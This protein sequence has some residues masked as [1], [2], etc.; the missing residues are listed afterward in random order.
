MS[1]HFL[2]RFRIY[3]VMAVLG[4]AFTSSLPA[5]EKWLYGH[6]AHFEMLSSA[7]EKDSRRL[8]INL[9][10]FRENVLAMFPARQMEEPKV[11]VVLFGSDS[12]FKAYKPRY[13]GKPKDVAGYFLNHP[14]QVY[15]A[16]CTDYDADEN[17]DPEEIIFH[18]YLH[19]LVHSRGLTLP[20]WLNEGMAEVFSTF[21]LEDKYA[22]YGAP[23][24]IYVDIMGL[25][26]LMPLERMLMVDE[27]SP[28]YNEE[29]RA[30]TFYAQSWL[31]T[32][33]LLCG[34]DREN[35][36]RLAKF[37]ERTDGMTGNPK[38]AFR[39]IFGQSVGEME[40]VLRSYLSG[41]QFYQRRMPL[42]PI[43]EKAI[44]VRP[45]SELEREL[46]LTSLRWR[47]HQDPR[48]VPALF[49]L[50]DRDPK[51]PGPHETLAAVALVKNDVEGALSHWRKAAELK[52]DNPFVYTQAARAALERFG[53]DDFDERLTPEEA[54]ELQ[55]WLDR[56]LTLRPGYADAVEALAVVESRAPT[57]RIYGVNLIQNSMGTMKDRDRTL[58]CLA[59]IRWRAKDFA[60][61]LSIV[62][63]LIKSGQTD[64]KV[65]S[66]AISLK[67]R[68]IAD[69]PAP[70][71]PEARAADG[72]P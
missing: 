2:H 71:A 53:M 15:I 10:R 4:L 59:L 1:F 36:K 61:C 49:A 47:V 11:T 50:A 56:A 35:S 45:A 13:K 23:K 19:L 66:A 72:T 62:E 30:T 34:K 18:E 6:S 46:V 65:R 40:L 16:M 64:P 3:S 57:I 33:Y 52:T 42:L 32:H 25:S 39:E 44:V 38:E 9:E 5:A 63:A 12:G 70:A 58:L 14:D 60:T 24:Q 26:A 20:L 31:L 41:G 7:K 27:K 17:G 67:L 55:R 37:L 8:L 28:E 22:E 54:F 48:D 51:A 68:A 69:R 43:D 29:E 21:K